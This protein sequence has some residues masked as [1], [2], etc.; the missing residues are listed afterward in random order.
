[1]Y[2]LPLNEPFRNTLTSVNDN[3]VSFS[4]PEWKNQEMKSLNNQFEKEIYRAVPLSLTD[5]DSRDQI[6]FLSKPER[7]NTEKYAYQRRLLRPE[8]FSILA[9]IVCFE[10]TLIVDT[11]KKNNQLEIFKKKISELDLC[12]FED[13]PFRM[14]K[15]YDNKVLKKILFQ[16]INKGS[17]N[18]SLL[19]ILLR[20]NQVLKFALSLVSKSILFKRSIINS[21]NEKTSCYIEMKVCGDYFQAAQSIKV[22]EKNIES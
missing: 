4:I 16:Y 7:P 22:K 8:D 19:E 1:M 12:V 21:Y 18:V 14:Q 10:Q 3:D 5:F 6:E 2:S 9:F 13:I 17:Y 20:K 11:H 15:H